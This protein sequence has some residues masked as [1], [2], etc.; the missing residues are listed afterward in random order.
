M[1]FFT[2]FLYHNLDSAEKTHYLP[3]NSHRMD[4][5]LYT[6]AFRNQSK[7]LDTLRSVWVTVKDRIIPPKKNATSS[8]FKI[9]KAKKR[10][11]TD[12]FHQV[13]MKR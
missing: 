9:P 3:R 8:F 6:N 12:S 5:M 13:E 7:A 2:Q 4:W 11:C 10:A 1:D